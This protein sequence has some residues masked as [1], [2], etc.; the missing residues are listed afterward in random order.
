[1][2]SLQNLIEKLKNRD[3][4]DGILLAGSQAREEHKGHS[5]IDLLVVLKENSEQIFSL[6][7][8]I[9]DK[10]ADIFFSDIPSLKKIDE[11]E[12]IPSNTMEAVFLDWLS[13]GQIMFDKSKT[14]SDLKDK[15][16][17]LKKKEAVPES[18][19]RKF[20]SLI[21]HGYITNKRYFISKD[22]EY[23]RALEVKLLSD[24]NNILVGYFEFRNIPWRGEKKMLKY[25]AE[26]DRDFYDL[27]FSF[28]Q[29]AKNVNEKFAIYEKL[30]TK[31]FVGKYHLWDKNII[32]PSIK[33]P[34]E[35]QKRSS[36]I[37]YWED[38]T[39]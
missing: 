23:L 25:L 13:E 30:L 32:S 15:C 29:D 20:E 22:P 27:F 4:I 24:I 6:L 14:L 18:E 9:D 34:M 35:E 11:Q 28:I 26:N 36:L 33:G 19:M 5:D 38:L 39:K 10:P 12:T 3:E 2:V 21:N 8:F 1:M 37:K 31:V 16:S 7:Q 17:E